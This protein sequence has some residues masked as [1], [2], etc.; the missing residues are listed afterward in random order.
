[1]IG[2]WETRVVN[3]TEGR[4]EYAYLSTYI[5]TIN[6]RLSVR[7]IFPII[8]SCTRASAISPWSHT[9]AD[10]IAASIA[11]SSGQPF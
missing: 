11:A 2:Y 4:D 9:A 10:T 3:R 7:S 1:M 5:A 8:T 6:K